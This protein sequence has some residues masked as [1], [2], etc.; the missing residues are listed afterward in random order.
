MFVLDTNALSAIMASRPVPEVAAW[1][2]SQPEELLFTVAVCQ[3]EILAGIEILPHGRRRRALEMAARAIFAED[4]DGR[5]LPFDQT[6]ACLYAELFAARK[7]AGRPTATADLMIAAVARANG[8]SMVTRD[9]SDF[10]GC[11]L[12]LINPWDAA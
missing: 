5:I 12:T 6:A 3:A 4:F 9:I 10:E 1:V 7:Q 2:A 8:A 11:G